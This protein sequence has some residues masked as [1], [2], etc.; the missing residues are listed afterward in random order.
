M[1]DKQNKTLRFQCPH[2]SVILRGKL[3]DA[4]KERKCPKCEQRFRIPRPR[5]AEPDTA[6]PKKEPLI[7]VVCGVC[8]TRVYATYGQIGQS[9]ECPDCFTQN[10][11]KE[12]PKTSKPTPPVML[13]GMGY[14][15]E[16]V[17]EI[18][19]IKSRGDDLMDKA[20]REVE[21]DRRSF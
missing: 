21:R 7:P 12:P 13:T 3:L 4:G 10:L 2:C 16:P 8:Q 11:V 19:I 17:R 20:E 15:M 1:S 14:E 5:N 18:Q 9:M 6:P